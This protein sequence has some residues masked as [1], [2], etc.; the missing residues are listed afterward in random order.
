MVG[1]PPPRQKNAK[2]SPTAANPF[3][4][5][6]R[7]PV[8]NDQYSLSTSQRKSIRMKY[9]THLVGMMF[10]IIAATAIHADDATFDSNG[11]TIRYVTAGEGEPVV[12]IHGWMA[13]STMWGRDRAGNTK[14]NTENTEGF[15]L[16]AFDCRGHGKSDKPHDPTMYGTEMAADVVRLLDHLQIDKAHLI[17]YSSGAFIAGHVAATHPQRVL[18]IVYGGQAPLVTGGKSSDSSEVDVFAKAVEEGKDLGAYI[19]AV[20]PADKPKPTE[21]Q[22]STMAKFMFHGKDVVAL[23]AAGRSFGQLRVSTED[24]RQCDAPILFIHGGNERDDVKESV[25]A[26]HALL[27]RGEIKIIEGGDHITT[28]AKPEFSAAVVEFLQ[29]NRQK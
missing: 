7:L 20:M 26:V 5:L 4:L 16:I 8:P 2:I 25:A 21:A 1:A 13:D 10:G 15:Q 27:G 17:G 9:V 23:A 29:S 18:S 12:L 11:V 22:A 3:R 24:L 14:L 6:G 19:L 28:L